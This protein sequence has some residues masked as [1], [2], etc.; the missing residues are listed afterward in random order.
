MENDGFFSPKITL[1]HDILYM[2]AEDYYIS[3]PCQEWK[4]I[5]PNKIH[6][7][8]AFPALSAKLIFFLKVWY[9]FLWKHQGWSFYKM[10]YYFI[11]QNSIKERVFFLRQS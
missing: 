9:C 5:F 6:Q 11:W 4:I 10:Q 7:N 8:M 2:V 1:K 3:F